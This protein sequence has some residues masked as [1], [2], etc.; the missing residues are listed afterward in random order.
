MMEARR[1]GDG[2]LP[3][4]FRQVGSNQLQK[5]EFTRYLGRQTAAPESRPART[6]VRA[7]ASNCLQKDEFTKKYGGLAL[8]HLVKQF[9]EFREGD[10]RR[11]RSMN[12]RIARCLQR[13]H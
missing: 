5:H 3:M 1:S 6:S 10:R 12:H 8:R 2:K 4:H 11:L 13:S 7:G 9:I